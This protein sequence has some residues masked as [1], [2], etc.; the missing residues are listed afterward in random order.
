MKMKKV[1]EKLPW[2]L[3]NKEN[4]SFL[5]PFYSSR[6]EVEER[7]V[8]KIE[9]TFLALKRDFGIR[10]SREKVEKTVRGAYEAREVKIGEDIIWE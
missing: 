5:P 10:F 1:E 7:L 4:F 6:E 9:D 8:S 2:G 3:Y